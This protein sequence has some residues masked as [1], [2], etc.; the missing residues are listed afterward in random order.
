[1]PESGPIS[2]KVALVKFKQ[3][4]NVTMST[5][6]QYW[7][8]STSTIRCMVRKKEIQDNALAVLVRQKWFP[9]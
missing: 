4:L 1:M 5:L 6:V 8:H 9:D 2:L 3:V 7:K